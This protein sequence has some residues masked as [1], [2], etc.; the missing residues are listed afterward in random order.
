MGAL[1]GYSCRDDDG[2]KSIVK[3]CVM[4]RVPQTALSMRLVSSPA[5]A[6]WSGAVLGGF[7]QF[8]SRTI[9]QITATQATNTN[10][11]MRC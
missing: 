5:S 10:L 9:P 2:P 4:Y 6:F 11:P 3:S 7:T 1:L 8:P